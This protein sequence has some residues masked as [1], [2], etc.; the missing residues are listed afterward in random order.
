MPATKEQAAEAGYA[1]SDAYAPPPPAPEPQPVYVEPYPAEPPPSPSYAPPVAQPGLGGYGP[2]GGY[3]FTPPPPPPPSYQPG[4][5][6]PPVSGDTYMPGPPQNYVPGSTYVLPKSEWAP[7]PPNMGERYAAATVNPTFVPGTGVY[8][9]GAA[10]GSVPINPSPGLGAGG[11]ADPPR[12]FVPGSTY[13][14]PW[15]APYAPR[16]TYPDRT[17]TEWY[18]GPASVG[19]RG[20]NN[21]AAVETFY[22]ASGAS[23]TLR[24]TGYL[25]AGVRAYYPERFGGFGEFPPPAAVDQSRAD[26]FN[27]MEWGRQLRGSA[28]D[29]RTHR[30]KLRGLY[31]GGS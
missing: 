8:G 30:E 6:A 15:H 23:P 2:G 29:P 12:T 16:P 22:P 18:G 10:A 31:G 24:N 3:V 14:P 27:Q 19:D 5:T 11:P 20:I 28:P 17:E 21:N 13:V 1:P 4:D 7:P 26:T 25:P 9:R